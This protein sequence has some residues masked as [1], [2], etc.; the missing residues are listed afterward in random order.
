MGLRRQRAIAQH[1]SLDIV[2]ISCHNTTMKDDQKTL[3]IRLSAHLLEQMREAA[4]QNNRS[5]N[6]EV[7]QAMEEHIKKQ[8]K[9]K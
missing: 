6:G 3:T 1:S 8:K 2:A 5:L 9:G 7:L 4:K